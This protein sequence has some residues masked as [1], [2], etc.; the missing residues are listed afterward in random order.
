MEKG[1]CLDLTGS[2]LIEETVERLYPA[3]R[4][5]LTVDGKIYGAPTGVWF[6]Y[7]VISEEAWQA[8]GMPADL[9]PDTLDELFDCAELFCDKLEDKEFEEKISLL[10]S[11]DATVYTESS[12]GEVFTGWIVENYIMQ[13]K[14]AELEMN[15]DPDVLVPLLNRGRELGKRLYELESHTVTDESKELGLLDDRSSSAWAG[16]AYDPIVFM[17]ITDDEPKLISAQL[18]I[19]SAFAQTEYPE[20]CV[21]LLEDILKMNSEKDCAF[22]FTDA[23]PVVNPNYESD[24]AEQRAFVEQTQKKLEN[25]DLD[26]AER[27]DL[28]ENLAKQQRVLDILLT[29]D[30]EKY[31]LSPDKLK[32]YQETIGN[33]LYFE[34]P[35]FFSANGSQ[36]STLENL[37][38]QVCRRCHQRGTVYK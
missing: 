14:Y 7:Y 10:S 5:M 24:L 2:E 34:E 19:W 3:F 29:S 8:A 23:E 16:T 9:I 20:L 31:V 22:L 15:F 6:D 17:R 12:Y 28:E 27:Q 36:G 37:E 30:D 33:Y 32:M 35:N 21:E 38:K 25:P 1:Y 18:S 11:W 4:E 26:W 13:L